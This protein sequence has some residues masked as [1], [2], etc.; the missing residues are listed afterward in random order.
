LNNFVRNFDP[1]NKFNMTP[2]WCPE[3][4]NGFTMD[5]PIH[6]LSNVHRQDLGC[7]DNSSI[8]LGSAFLVD[9]DPDQQFVSVLFG[10]DSVQIQGVSGGSGAP[11]MSAKLNE[12]FALMAQWTMAQQPRA[13]P[14][15]IAASTPQRAAQ[16]TASLDAIAF[17]ATALACSPALRRLQHDVARAK[18]GAAL[19]LAMQN[20]DNDN[21]ST[22]FGR[23]DVSV[24]LGASSDRAF[25]NLP[26]I[27]EQRSPLVAP[28]LAFEL[29]TAAD[30]L[31]LDV[32]AALATQRPGGDAVVDALRI[33]VRR[34]ASGVHW[35][36]NGNVN[37]TRGALLARNYVLSVALTPSET[38]LLANRALVIAAASSGDVLAEE[39]R[40][41]ML[42]RVYP[43][44]LRLRRADAT[45]H[46]AVKT[47]RFGQ[48]ITVRDRLCSL[49]TN[50]RLPTATSVVV[51][52]V[53][54]PMRARPDRINN[55]PSD[56]VLLDRRS[57]PTLHTNASG[58]ASPL[59][60]T[61]RIALYELPAPRQPLRSQVFF[62][63]FG[64]D[65]RVLSIRHVIDLFSSIVCEFEQK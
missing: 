43:R 18:H 22:T 58:L 31:L 47:W 55:A 56:G 34:A 44:V 57:S 16:L 63:V 51:R 28:Q 20:F 60:S 35:L 33:G 45:A 10:V 54:S 48:E 4:L 46:V 14:Q 8:T 39:R 6:V 38:A 3:G 59:L 5:A 12:N 61:R 15:P 30:R 41:G 49:H 62:T 1:Q 19:R 65:A 36:L 50:Y 9:I 11:A 7:L 24:Q 64:R 29:H 27:A 17:D 53:A 26:R 25:P 13:R 42:L 52:P 2:W 23:G 32:G 37:T 40:D 21:R